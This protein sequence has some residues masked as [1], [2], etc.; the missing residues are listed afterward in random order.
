MDLAVQQSS[1]H[2]DRLEKIGFVGRDTSFPSIL[3]VIRRMVARF[4]NL[5]SRGKMVPNRRG[6]CR[7]GVFVYF[8]LGEY[9]VDD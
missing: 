9:D 5:P 4:D 2:I 8:L 3:R 7:S 6:S 1:G